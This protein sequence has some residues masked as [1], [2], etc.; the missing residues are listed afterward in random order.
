[1][2]SNGRLKVTDFGFARI[3]ARDADESKRLTFCGTDAYMSPEILIG[4]EFDLPTDIFSLGV[5]FCE[6]LARK[7]ADDY[8]FKRSAP[9]WGMDEQQVRQLASPGCPPDLIKLALECC[10]VKPA[11]RPTMTDVLAR[12]RVIEVEVAA[13]AG[14]DDQHV[15]SIKFMSSSKRPAAA[16]RIP[17]FGMGIGSGLGKKAGVDEDATIVEH[18]DSDEE[19]EA[20]LKGL[21]GIKLQPDSH[22]GSITTSSWIAPQDFSRSNAEPDEEPP[23][24]DLQGGSGFA[25]YSTTVIKHHGRKETQAAPSAA[26]VLTLRRDS[27]PVQA[28]SPPDA[29][30]GQPDLPPSADS[31]LS[32]DTYHTAKGLGSVMS[33]MA[34]SIAAATEGGSILSSTSNA[35]LHHRFTLIKPGAKKSGSVAAVAQGAA[36]SELANGKENV[37]MAAS[38][39]TPG[40]SPFDLFFF[41]G[42]LGSFNHKCDLCGKRIGWKPSLECDDCGYR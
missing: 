8:T 19:L 28:A 23:L 7:L 11:K 21:E 35:A 4:D 36:S 24:I 26:S 14:P 13:A 18:S 37:G 15:G 27:L 30:A 38:Q 42:G 5:I 33:V 6:I 29:S 9:Y 20:A 1:M 12:L 16:L 25:E 10:N 39:S 40:W 32:I 3:A 41:S 22:V 17:S 31:L 34:P 2:T